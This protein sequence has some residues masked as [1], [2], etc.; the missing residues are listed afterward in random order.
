MLSTD[1]ARFCLPL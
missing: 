1:E